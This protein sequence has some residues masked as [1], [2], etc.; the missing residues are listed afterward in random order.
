MKILEDFI[1]VDGHILHRIQADRN[2]PCQDVKIGDLG[3]WVEKPENVQDDAWVTGYLYGDAVACGTA[4]VDGMAFGNSYVQRNARIDRF[5]KVYDNAN[6]GGDAV[7]TDHSVVRGN[8]KVSDHAVVMG[9][10]IVSGNAIVCS[11]AKIHDFVHVSGHTYIAGD[12]SLRDKVVVE[13]DVTIGD[14]V[15]IKDRVIVKG[16]GYIVNYTRIF[17]DLVING[18]D[19]DFKLGFPCIIKGRGEI[20]KNDDIIFVSNGDESYV[21][22]KPLNQGFGNPAVLQKVKELCIR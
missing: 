10:A 7:I 11:G 17:G 1:T 6:I 21:F 4:R 12:V 18:E 13:G 14:H 20:R 22:I 5:A 9:Y 16:H 15:I 19:I 2:I 8:A 3:G